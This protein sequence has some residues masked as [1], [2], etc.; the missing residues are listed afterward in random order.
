MELLEGQSLATELLGGPP[1]LSRLLDIS[2]QL[3]DAL[4]AAHTKGII[5]RDVKPA[6]VFISQRG[7][8][9]VLDFGLAKITQKALMAMETVGSTQDAPAH[10]T[11]PGSTVGTS[12]TCLPS[13]R[14]VKYSIPERIC[15]RWAQ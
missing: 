6:N 12:P 15:S 14:A 9:K 2:I 8:V 11:S 3:A 13:R 1:P 10:L 4:D 5:H 7:Q